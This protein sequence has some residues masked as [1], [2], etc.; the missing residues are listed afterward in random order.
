MNKAIPKPPRTMMGVASPTGSH[1]PV[2]EQSVRD[3]PEGGL[4][5]EHGAGLYSTVLLARLGVR[6]LCCEPHTGWREW[7][8]WVYPDSIEVSDT[9]GAALDRLGDAAVVFLDGP[10]KERGVLL[11]ACLE[12]RVPVIVVHDTGKRE[13][14]YYGFERHMF[15][16]PDYETW[17]QPDD[18]HKTMRWTLKR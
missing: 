14:N 13:W 5:I 11:Q 1:L 17:L 9:V 12:K 2:L 3:M 6:A 7:A 18:P 16:H 8:R 10:A 15:E 4:V